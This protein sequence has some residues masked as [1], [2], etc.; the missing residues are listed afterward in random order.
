MNHLLK[1]NPLKDLSEFGHDIKKHSFE[2]FVR[3]WLHTKTV[4]WSFEGIT[5]SNSSILWRSQNMS[6]R[7][8]CKCQYIFSSHCWETCLQSV[9]K[10]L[11][12][13]V[14]SEVE[15]LLQKV[16]W[17][18]IQ[19]ALPWN[20]NSSSVLWRTQK[21]DPLKDWHLKRFKQFPM[22][23]QAE[24]IN[25]SKILWRTQKLSQ[26]FLFGSGP[27][28]LNPLFIQ[29]LLR[30]AS[31]CRTFGSVVAQLR[32]WESLA[33]DKQTYVSLY[34]SFKRFRKLPMQKALEKSPWKPCEKVIFHSLW[35]KYFSF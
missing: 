16:R 34:V 22:I 1:N 26:M 17:L 19:T 25:N 14:S 30:S 6:Q 9:S 11:M 28:L 23:I 31:L 27:N 33:V 29:S 18:R 20:R 35:K 13:S 8:T 12:W 7:N 15:N 3:V 10:L 4:D 32:S 5:Q 2:G 24:T 21:I